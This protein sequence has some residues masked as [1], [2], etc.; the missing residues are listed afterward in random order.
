MYDQ[1]RVRCFIVA[2]IS[3]LYRFMYRQLSCHVWMVYSGRD[4]TL[5]HF[6]VIPG[7]SFCPLLALCPP[8]FS[9]SGPGLGL[10]LVWSGSGP[11]WSCPV[12]SGLVWSGPVWSCPFLSCLVSALSSRIVSCRVLSCR[13]VSCRVVS[14]RVVSCRVILFLVV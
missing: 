3:D 13:V 11:I 4:D 10:G 5:R 1:C 6:E 7:I 9:G 2:V 8:L 14:C 12:L